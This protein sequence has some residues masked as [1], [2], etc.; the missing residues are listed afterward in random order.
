VP[1]FAWLQREDA[2][3]GGGAR[4][5]LARLGQGPGGQLRA[6]DPRGKAEV[7]LDPERGPGLAAQRRALH[8]QR[9]QALGG[10]V[11]CRPQPGGTTADDHQV[12]LLAPL[13]RKTDAQSSGHVAGGRVAQ[14]AATGKAH[15]R[16]LVGAEFL[17]RRRA[18]SV[19]GVLP[20]EGEP[21]APRVLDDLPRRFRGARTDDLHPHALLLERFA[22]GHERR[23]E[24]VPERAVLEQERPQS[25]PVHRD[26]PHRLRGHRG[27]I[28]RLPRHQVHLAQEAGRS[29]AN[30]LAPVGI[31]DRRLPF[32][33]R[34]Q[35]VALIPDLKEHVPSRGDA[36]LPV[37]PE[38]RELR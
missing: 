32:E 18:V 24:H 16:D 30:D 15:E 4:V 7:V 28:D 33:D 35:P 34:D 10:A 8:H 36:L 31:Q 17:E 5:E 27:Q 12:D 9:L 22:P 38:C 19:L 23:Q 2:I 13:E 3:R 21:V 20:G 37:L 14:L 26:V 29:V 6:A 1:V 25:V 11:D